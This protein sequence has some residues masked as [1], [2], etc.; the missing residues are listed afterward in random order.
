MQ[1]GFG[2]HHVLYHIGIVGA[3]Y[4]RIN[5]P[6]IL[7]VSYKV[8][9]H[10]MPKSNHQR[11]AGIDVDINGA[12][13][14]TIAIGQPVLPI[15]LHRTLEPHDGLAKVF[16]GVVYL[17]NSFLFTAGNFSFLIADLGIPAHI[18]I[19]NFLDMALAIHI[20]DGVLLNGKPSFIGFPLHLLRLRLHIDI[21]LGSSLFSCSSDTLGIFRLGDRL[22]TGLRNV[23]RSHFDSG[24]ILCCVSAELYAGQ[25]GECLSCGRVVIDASSYALVS[26]YTGKCAVVGFFSC[27]GRIINCGRKSLPYAILGCFNGL[28]AL[29]IGNSCCYGLRSSFHI[30]L[31]GC[32]RQCVRLGDHRLDLIDGDPGNIV[33][34]F[35]KAALGIIGEVCFIQSAHHLVAGVLLHLRRIDGRCGACAFLH[36]LLHLLRYGS[37]GSI[38]GLA[39][40]VI[41]NGTHR[42]VAA[43]QYTTGKG[44]K[45]DIIAEV[46]HLVTVAGEGLFNGVVDNILCALLNAFGESVPQPL[47]T[48]G[49]GE[50]IQAGGFRHQFLG[51]GLPGGRLAQRAIQTA[52]LFG[53]HGSATGSGAE[54]ECCIRI[55]V[56]LIGICIFIARGGCSHHGQTGAGEDRVCNK[57]RHHVRD[58]IDQLQRSALNSTN[59][60]YILFVAQFC[61]RLIV[62]DGDFSL[63]GKPGPLYGFGIAY[64]A[65]HQ[66]LGFPCLRLWIAG[67]IRR[68]SGGVLPHALECVLHA[69]KDS[70]ACLE[71]ILVRVVVLYRFRISLVLPLGIGV[72][73]LNG[74]LVGNLLL[75]LGLL[76]HIPSSHIGPG[77]NCRVIPLFLNRIQL[78][79]HGIALFTRR[80]PS[81]RSLCRLRA[82]GRG[83]I[84]CCLF[85]RTRK[86]TN[87]TPVILF[88]FCGF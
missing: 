79:L 2:I 32:L 47:A 60:G 61:L 76:R 38:Q 73:V 51:H 42:S 65:F 68:C 19:G 17:R 71:F 70:I 12:I 67:E 77:L 59:A 6:G 5:H 28:C 84:L 82:G 63:I 74:S 26:C 3:L 87:A 36:A 88:Q 62:C 72:L 30:Q 40:T 58:R 43:A 54:Y 23:L 9:K 37:R 83:I 1:F 4:Q 46:V 34:D 14:C 56:L 16:R 10:L 85:Y 13:R 8:V 52:K 86:F 35:G 33:L 41:G 45:Q 22:F 50:V 81:R 24:N 80:S 69:R 27:V 20:G 55:P 15:D 21:K 53:K 44:T 57:G 39:Y 18:G 11:I 48:H 7:A 66:P 64:A 75:L 31:L 49:I 25:L 29:R 78:L